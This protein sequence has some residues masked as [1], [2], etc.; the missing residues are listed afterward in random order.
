M[1]TFTETDETRNAQA[2]IARIAEALGCSEEIFQDGD[3][4][5]LLRTLELIELWMSI[6]NGQDRAKMLSY[7][8]TIAS[9]N[10]HVK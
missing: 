4:N 8:R 5:D 7:A 1:S 3:S 9:Q 2:M 10:R 6:R